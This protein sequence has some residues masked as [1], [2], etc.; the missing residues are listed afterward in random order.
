[1]ALQEAV[2]QAQLREGGGTVLFPPGTFLLNNTVTITK[3]NIVLR[4]S[5]VSLQLQLWG[6]RALCCGRRYRMTWCACPLFSA[7]CRPLTRPRRPRRAA[8]PP[9]RRA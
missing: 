9:R 4:G 2:R 7:L 3:P 8:A 5:G 6:P 1:M